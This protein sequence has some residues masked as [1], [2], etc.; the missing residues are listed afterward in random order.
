MI[1]VTVFTQDLVVFKTTKSKLLL[2]A[3][4]SLFLI[5]YSSSCYQKLYVGYEV[6]SISLIMNLF[7]SWYSMYLGCSRFKLVN[8]GLIHELQFWPEILIVLDFSR[9]I[10][11]F[12]KENSELVIQSESEDRPKEIFQELCT[13][14]LNW[15]ALI[16][17]E[18]SIFWIFF[19]FF[20]FFF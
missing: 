19:Y 11:D 16:I 15:C 9:L 7:T 14:I 2:C 1:I 4:L 12:V 10:S 3:R 6:C 8:I 18:I 13:P 17:G 20:S 5:T